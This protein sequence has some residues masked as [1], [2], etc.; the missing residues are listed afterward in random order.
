[1]RPPFLLAAALLLAPAAAAPAAD[2]E[3]WTVLCD[4]TNNF[5]AWKGPAGDWAAVAGVTVSAK[6]PKML[7]AREGTGV[8]YNGPKGKTRDLVTK[9]TFGD[10][11][12][13]LEF[14]IPKGS[15]S[16]V[17]LHGHY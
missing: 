15:N 16:G 6:N 1:M 3:G 5:D 14:L 10:Q 4:G 13:H 12:V 11:E 7:E 2:A 8:I 9:Q 17:K